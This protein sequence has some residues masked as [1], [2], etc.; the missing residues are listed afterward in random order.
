MMNGYV[1]V[2]LLPVARNRL[3]QYKEIACQAGALWKEHGAQ[4][5]WECVGDDL[6]V[7]DMRSFTELAGATAD[8][9][10][11]CSWIVYDSR[12]QRDQVNA[13]VMADPRMQEMMAVCEQTFD[14][15]RMA[16]GGFGPLVVLC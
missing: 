1:D 14:C 8:E 6:Q 2:F 12:E 11:V 7:D 10:V 5:Y 9:V 16:C 13:A 3:D 15:K 4:K